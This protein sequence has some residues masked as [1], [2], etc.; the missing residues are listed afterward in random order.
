MLTGAT[1]FSV[2][3]TSDFRQACDLINPFQMPGSGEIVV[4]ALNA[5][6]DGIPP[7]DPEDYYP[8]PVFV[9][10]SKGTPLYSFMLPGIQLFAFTD[11][12]WLGASYNSTSGLITIYAYPP[13]P[14]GK[15]LW[16]TVVSN[17]TLKGIF[18]YYWPFW[19]DAVDF[20]AELNRVYIFMF[21]TGIDTSLRAFDLADGKLLWTA[22]IPAWYYSLTIASCP[23]T[24]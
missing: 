6:E 11:K 19:I 24:L 17:Y 18:H 23:R 21:L 9:F 16:K 4:Q 14:E 15:P 20:D 8:N 1:N 7:I 3:L 12:L 13:G 10:D 22:P 2:T 5:S